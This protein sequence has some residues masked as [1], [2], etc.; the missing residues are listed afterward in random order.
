VLDAGCGTGRVAVRLSA[1]L[2]PGGLLLAGFGL[3][4]A[5]LPLASAPVDL[6]GYDAWCAAAGLALQQRFATWDGDEYRGGGYAVSI[7]RRPAAPPVR[8][9]RRASHRPRAR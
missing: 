7:H 2:R 3:S 5:H 1:H 9:R 4:P 6:A 8:P